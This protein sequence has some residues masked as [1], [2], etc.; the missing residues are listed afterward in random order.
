MWSDEVSWSDKQ[1]FRVSTD[2]ICTLIGQLDYQ[3]IIGERGLAIAGLALLL[4]GMKDKSPRIIILCTDNINVLQR[5]GSAKSDGRVTSKL[6]RLIR[7][8]CIG[9][10]VEVTPR[11]TRSAR[12]TSSVD[13][14]M[15]SQYE[16]D[17]WLLTH[18]LQWVGIPEQWSKWAHEWKNGQKRP[19]CRPFQFEG[20]CWIFTKLSYARCGV[21]VEFL[22][23]DPNFTRATNTFILHRSQK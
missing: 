5:F 2:V 19:H 17:R 14:T 18:G 21:D 3:L 8:W 13:L 1:A 23:D 22:F 10:N 20:N 6:L 16:C 15:W 7:Q 4:W 9:N 11:Y 12:N